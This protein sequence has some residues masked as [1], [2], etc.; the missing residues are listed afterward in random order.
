MAKNTLFWIAVFVAAACG[1]YV[2]AAFF[3]FNQK[4]ITISEYPDLFKILVGTVGVAVC[5][6]FIKKNNWHEWQ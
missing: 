4:Q 5:Y 2:A 6:N 1:A 3:D